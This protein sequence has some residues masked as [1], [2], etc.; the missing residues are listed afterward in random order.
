L[1]DPVP[2]AD[3]VENHPRLRYASTVTTIDAVH[4]GSQLDRHTA[5]VRR[6]GMADR[7]VVTKGDIAGKEEV[8]RLVKRL[9][10]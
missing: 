1:A 7:L 2:I 6:A 3:L 5:S 8:A 4:G 10:R 9:S